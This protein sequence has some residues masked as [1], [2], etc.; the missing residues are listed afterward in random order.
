MSQNGNS[1][2]VVIHAPAAMAAHPVA[3]SPE[4]VVAF[5][6]THIRELEKKLSERT[7][8]S[9]TIANAAINLLDR[10]CSLSDVTREGGVV[11]DKHTWERT[12]GLQL[13]IEANDLTNLLTIRAREVEKPAPV[14]WEDRGDD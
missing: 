3:P 1:R 2:D 10:V 14:A 7:V 4:E 12:R 11:I 9:N 13:T 5:Q 8:L 6:A